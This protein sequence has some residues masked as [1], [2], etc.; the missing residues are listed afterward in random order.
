MSKQL[1][2]SVERFLQGETPI[3][4]FVDTYFDAWRTERD[5]G[6][7]LADDPMLSEKLSSFFCLLE[8]YNPDTDR[9]EYEYDEGRLRAEMKK[10]FNGEKT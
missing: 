10:V 7:I 4:E 6:E 8:M 9:K 3:D 5:S 2:D 1:H